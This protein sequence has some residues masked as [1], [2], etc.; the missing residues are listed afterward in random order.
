MLKLIKKLWEILNR[1]LVDLGYVVLLVMFL[2]TIIQVFFR[3]V[4]NNPLPWPEEIAR[5]CF[6]WITFIGLVSNIRTDE[7]YRI[8]FIQNQLP[9]TIKS[10]I[11]IIFNAIIIIFLCFTLVGSSKL[12]EGNWHV[13]S[14]N[15]ISVNVIY[16]SLPLLSTVMIIQLLINSYNHA[17][18]IAKRSKDVIQ[19]GNI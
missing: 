8:D 16:I 6:V 3:Y 15:R 5:Y 2:S 19:R 11:E 18:K 4:L 13:L 17:V 10:I 14:A 9:E 12:I 1:I 7:H